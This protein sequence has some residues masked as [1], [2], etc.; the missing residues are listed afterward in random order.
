MP[1]PGE[2]R[3]RLGCRSTEAVAAAPVKSRWYVGCDGQG[4][5]LQRMG[6]EVSDENSGMTTIRPRPIG[7]VERHDTTGS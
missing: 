5:W 3:P 4:K 7:E 1:D 6:A 2:A